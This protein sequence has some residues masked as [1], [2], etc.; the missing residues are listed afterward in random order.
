M[1]ATI[2]MSPYV[3]VQGEVSRRLTNGTVAIRLGEREYVGAPLS[4]PADALK[5]VS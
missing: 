4:P 1:Y 3:Q 5:S 2:Q